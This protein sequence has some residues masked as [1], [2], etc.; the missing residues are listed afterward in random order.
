MVVC[1]PPCRVACIIFISKIINFNIKIERPDAGRYWRDGR[2]VFLE[3][4]GVRALL[5]KYPGFESAFEHRT[6]VGI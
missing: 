6:D 1:Q 3:R 4:D 5:E 2:F